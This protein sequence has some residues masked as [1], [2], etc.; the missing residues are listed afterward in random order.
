MDD[1][2][3]QNQGPQPPAA[4]DPA[5]VAPEAP[6]NASPDGQPQMS[7]PQAPAM[8]E[9]KGYGKRSKKQWIL[10]YVAVAAVVY[11]A[12]YYLFIHKSGSSGY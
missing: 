2:N 9:Q 7:Q 10:I 5:P 11:A 6:A 8:P 3:V 12:V 1:Q 4:P